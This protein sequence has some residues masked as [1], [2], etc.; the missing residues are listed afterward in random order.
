MVL[1]ARCKFLPGACATDGEGPFLCG[2]FADNIR[3]RV[4]G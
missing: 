4:E 2:S 3:Y 1:P